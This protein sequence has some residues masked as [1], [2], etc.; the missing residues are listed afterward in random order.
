MSQVSEPDETRPDFGPSGHT[1]RRAFLTGVAAC[2]ICAAAGGGIGWT[3]GQRGHGPPPLVAKSPTRTRKARALAQPEGIFSVE[4]DQPLV[5]L[6]FDDGPDPEYTP[7]V[8]R[9]LARHKFTATFFLVGV[10]V[11]A[12]RGLV[13][14][15][16]SGG[17]TIGNHT[18]SHPMLQTMKPAPVAA[19]I[20]RGEQAII[21]AGAPRPDLF[22]PPR[23]YTDTI[24]NVLADAHGYRTVFWTE[25]VER[26]IDSRPVREGVDKLLEKVGPGSIILAH[27]GG[28]IRSRGNPVH[29]RSRTVEALPHLFDGLRALGLRGVSVTELLSSAV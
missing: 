12:H 10:N 2:G 23:G 21:A 20:T 28:H 19:E 7:T 9:L 25:A 17:H 8:L 13:A 22:R 3:L 29:D 24:V 16:V 14:D 6:S 27:D 15:Q 26:Y 5:G 1:G 18:Y 11:R 4:T